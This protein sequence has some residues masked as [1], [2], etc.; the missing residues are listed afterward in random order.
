MMCHLRSSASHLSH[1][2]LVLG[3]W[4]DVSVPRRS[5]VWIFLMTAGGRGR[6]AVPR[7]L[8][9]NL[10]RRKIGTLW[11]NLMRR[12]RVNPLPRRH[13]SILAGKLGSW[14][15]GR[16]VKGGSIRSP[17]TTQ[18]LKRLPLQ[19]LRWP[20]FTDKGTDIEPEVGATVQLEICSVCCAEA[21]QLAR[22]GCSSSAAQSWREVGK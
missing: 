21:Y 16:R 19:W 12:K 3:S 18:R 22:S 13:R 5:I 4:D 2:N 11:Q 9:Q 14:Y 17:S 8:W 10:M 20:G 6:K 15:P 1:R 7:Y